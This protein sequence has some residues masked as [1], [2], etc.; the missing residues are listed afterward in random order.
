MR[1][2]RSNHASTSRP[3]LTAR[4]APDVPDGRRRRRRRPAA[5]AS[6]CPSPVSPRRGAP[7]DSFAPNA[8]IRIDR[9]GR[10]HADHAAGRD[11]PGHLHLRSRCCSPR[12]WRSTSTRCRSSRRRRTTSSTRN[13]LFGVQ[14]TGNSTS[15]R[16]FC[17]PLRAGRRRARTML[18]AA[19]AQHWD[20]DPDTCRA[21]NGEVIH[22]RERAH[23]RLW[24]AGRPGGARCRRRRRS[25][26]RTRKD[27]KLIGT[28]A[29][30]LD[31]PDKVNGK[32]GLRHRRHAAGHEV[33]APSPPARCSAAS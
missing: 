15:I 3:R 20:V 23:A 25:R 24:R 26:S 30:R 10:R 7:A 16:A 21:E 22:A 4:L 5:R 19:A 12:S 18:V 29:K 27:F 1:L 11:G 17:E 9:D 14:V 6:V 2:D 32:A 33:R 8:F 31:T 28:P 13:P